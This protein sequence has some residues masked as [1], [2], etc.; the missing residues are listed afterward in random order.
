MAN[1]VVPKKLVLQGNLSENWKR[2]HQAFNIYMLAAGYVDLSSERQVAILLNII[3]EEAVEVHGT[4]TY[5]NENDQK[6][7]K[8]VIEKFQLYCNPKKNILHER[9]IFYNR[10]QMDGETFDNFVTDVKILVQGCEFANS[11][12]LLRDKIVLFARDKDTKDR[13]IKLGNVSLQEAIDA[14]RIAE[15][16]RTQMKQMEPQSVD[17]VEIMHGR[18]PNDSL[19]RQGQQK[20]Q[21]AETQFQKKFNGSGTFKSTKSDGNPVRCSRCG[22]YHNLKGKC[23]AQGK[24]C[25]KCS[26]LNHFSS[27]CKS[28]EAVQEVGVDK[29]NEMFFIDEVKYVDSVVWLENLLVEDTFVDFKLDTGADV[30][31]ISRK[32]FEQICHESKNNFKIES[33]CPSLHAYNNSEIETCGQVRLNIMLQGKCLNLKFIIVKQSLCPILGL[34]ACNKLGLISRNHVQEVKQ[35]GDKTSL[36]NEFN[37]VFEG[38]G[39]FPTNYSIQLKENA[40]P[41]SKP[42]N[43]IPIKMQGKLKVELER[44]CKENII[45]K[46]EKPSP[47]VNKLVIVEKSNGSIRICLDPHELNK[48]TVKQYFSIPT[49]H[50]LSAKLS[51][52]KW[53]SSLDLKDGFWQIALDEKSSEY[54]TFGTM[55]GTFK[56]NRLPFGLN[57][58]AEVFSQKNFEVFGDL[59]N[60]FIYMDDLLV[61]AETE[62][63]LTLLVRKVLERARKFNVKFNKTKFQHQVKT[64]KYIG[65]V[66]EDGLVK[67]DPERIKAIVDYEQPQNKKDLQRFLGMIN[68]LRNY[69]PDLAGVS[70]PLRCLLKKNVEF[71]WYKEHHDCFNKLKSALTQDPILQ[72]F[73]INKEIVI[74][75]DSSQNAIGSVLLQDNKPVCYAS[76]SLSD[77]EARYAQI[78]KEFLAVLFACKKFHYY[79]YGRRIIIQTDHLPLISIMQK[80][81]NSIPSRRLQCIKL[82]LSR[83]NVTLV[84]VP[85]KKMF[86]ADALSR[87][88][89]S[90]HKGFQN[91]SENRGVDLDVSDVVHSVN[92]SDEIKTKFQAET[93]SDDVLGKIINLLLSNGWPKCKSNVD[94]S[95][96]YFY[97]LRDKI[98]VFDGLLFLDD[99][100]V[101]PKALVGFILQKLHDESHIGINKTKARAKVLFY[102][103]G[104]YKDIEEYILKCKVCEKFRVKNI[105]DPMIIQ[106]LSEFPFQKIACDIL[107]FARVPYL[108]VVD[109]YSRWIELVKLGSKDSGTIIKVLKRIFSMYGVPEKLV[110]DNMPFNSFEFQRFAS[111]WGLEIITSSPRYP[112]SNGLAEKGVDICKKMLKKSLDCNTELLVMLME[113]RATPVLGSPYSPSELLMGRLIRTKLPILNS[114]ILKPK[115]QN[116]FREINKVRNEKIKGYYDSRARKRKD[117]EVGDDV[118]YWDHNDKLWKRA[119]I[120][121]KHSTPRSFWIKNENNRVLRRNMTHLKKSGNPAI[122]GSQNAIRYPIEAQTMGSTEKWYDKCNNN[123]SRSPVIDEEENEMVTEPVKLNNENKVP[124]P[125]VNQ[126]FNYCTRSGRVVRPPKKIDM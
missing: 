73:D 16:H 74:Q 20:S 78:E 34:S 122:F 8:K 66:F 52:A 107:E 108:V 99:R 11:D 117:F 112:M 17:K 83:Y 10:K 64:V 76:K 124:V 33:N 125:K 90:V 19:R 93:A 95:F 56:F 68:Y 44:L 24:T 121:D 7:I 94:D 81:I 47:W 51:G 15:L 50:D 43:R 3:G 69:I 87:A 18:A 13:M 58:S 80:D 12:E 86:F 79:V 115:W 67:P 97:N 70:K 27:T 29:I 88:S 41:S 59:E 1:F 45:S 55:F 40:I 57:I 104:M 105:R 98:H 113:Y 126:D 101:V 63:Q 82:K 114:N 85:G 120:I 37:D 92:V 39:C 61:F 32:I 72:T 46:V 42:P 53:F 84:Y 91:K 23:P 36:V 2:F 110:A 35:A 22:L 116:D 48:C 89:Y 111:V 118:T 60:V 75:T 14:F 30:N 123:P 26:K 9:F 62:D 31:L 54:C 102:W 5:E 38:V 119:K 49:L 6:D 100:I 4:F 103:K 77:T 25:F 106:E 109:Y 96:K 28:V 65:H 71:V 21:P